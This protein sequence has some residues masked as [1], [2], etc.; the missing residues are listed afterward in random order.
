MF[1]AAFDVAHDS[2]RWRR[3][4]LTVLIAL[5]A[6]SMGY[7]CGPRADVVVRRRDDRAEVVRIPAGAEV[8]AATVLDHV[9]Q[10][11]WSL[12]VEQFCA[13]WGVAPPTSAGAA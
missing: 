5:S 1:D 13:A 9:R 3:F 6:L 2:R 11:L 12:D 10:Q 7:V 8:T 4:G